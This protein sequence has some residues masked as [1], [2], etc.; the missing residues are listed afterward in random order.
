MMRQSLNSLLLISIL[1]L[2]AVAETTVFPEIYTS[3]DAPGGSG[4]WPVSSRGMTIYSSD[5]FPDSPVLI[6]EMA[7]RPDR[8]QALGTE[9]GWDN[10]ELLFSVTPTAPRS[11]PSNFATNIRNSVTDQV[12][13][14]DD[15]WY[16]TVDVPPIEGQS[17]REFEWRFPL[18]EPYLYD[19][20]DGNLLVDW[21]FGVPVPEPRGSFD[22]NSSPTN[23]HA[24][25]WTGNANNANGGGRFAVVTQFTFEPVPEP[26]FG[27]GSMVAAF[28]FSG[29][30]RR[31]RRKL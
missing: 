28:G 14:F 25:I 11:L 29:L 15:E 7:V 31:H 13:V 5:G 27:V 16:V 19:P 30:L 18:N 4:P 6:T 3:S 21:I 22:T 20:G 23:D 1:G 8:T 24:A 10:L 9:F 12:S 26:A 2:S 17:A